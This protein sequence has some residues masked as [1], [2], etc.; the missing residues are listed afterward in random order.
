MARVRFIELVGVCFASVFL[1]V[2]ETAT[3]AEEPASTLTNAASKGRNPGSAPLAER[4]LKLLTEK[5]ALT[6]EQQAKTN[7]VLQSLNGDL[8]KLALEDGMLHAERVARTRSLYEEADKQIRLA[9][10]GQQQ[11]QLD[12][13]EHEPHSELHVDL[14][15]L[16]VD[17][18]LSMLTDKLTLT[19]DQ[20]NKVRTALEAM[21]NSVETLSTD[22]TASHQDR[23]EQVRALREQAD[24][25][26][27][28]VLDGSQLDKLDRL[29]REPHAD[30]HGDLNGSTA[31]AT[32]PK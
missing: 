2:T 30:L 9:L 7:V 14:N 32:N 29:E 11:A 27:R 13:L 26:I 28:R 15:G 6:G 23:V 16:A 31:P 1:L 10:N 19:G 4:Q 25:E 3:W 8:R 17:E 20:Q 18:K 24:K 22:S 12:A 21:Q 5:L